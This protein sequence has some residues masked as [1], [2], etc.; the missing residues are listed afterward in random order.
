MAEIDLNLLSSELAAYIRTLEEKN[1]T[2]EQKIVKQ[3]VQMQNLYEMLVNTRKHTFGQSSEQSKYLSDADQMNFFNEAEKEFNS[4]AAEPTEQTIRVAE[5]TRKDKRTK[6]E[7]TE[8]LPHYEI[9]CTLEGEDKICDICGAE[10]VCIGKEKVRS[11]LVIIPQQMAVVDYFRSSYKCAACEKESGETLIQKAVVPAP[12][13]K[14]S[15]AAPA[16]VAYVMQEKYENAV[17][18]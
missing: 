3:Q 9:D 15:M 8:S 18:L 12:V 13:M 7:L 4:G 17:P 1:K 5:H 2:L 11:E 10:L 14:K 16:T 6:E